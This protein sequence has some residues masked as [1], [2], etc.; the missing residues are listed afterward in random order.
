MAPYET[1]FNSVNLNFQLPML[2]IWSINRTYTY[3]GLGL[4]HL[5]LEILKHETKF[6]NMKTQN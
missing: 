3:F 5:L 4:S 6:N 2:N 1:F